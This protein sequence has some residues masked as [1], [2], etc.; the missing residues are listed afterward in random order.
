MPCCGEEESE[1][2]MSGTASSRRNIATAHGG[3]V[4]AA[5]R[6]DDRIQGG[7]RKWRMTRR[8]GRILCGPLWLSV[9]VH[10]RI[11]SLNS[12]ALPLPRQD[13]WHRLHL[14]TRPWTPVFLFMKPVAVAELPLVKSLY[15]VNRSGNFGFA[16]YY[17]SWWDI[18]WRDWET[19]GILN[20][21]WGNRSLLVW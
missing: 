12:F 1:Q 17:I 4:P 18:P 19:L 10:G 2:Q 5:P 14:A 7:A 21:E 9:L 20:M 11:A 15:M 6:A 8:R 13:R 3:R 16:C